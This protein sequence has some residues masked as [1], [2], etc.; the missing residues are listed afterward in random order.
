[1]L[2]GRSVFAGSVFLLSLVGARAAETSPVQ[3]LADV[4]FL[5]QYGAHGLDLSDGGPVVRGTVIVN[6]MLIPNLELGY[7]CFY[8]MRLIVSKI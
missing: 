1:M 2:Q 5:S 7:T 6:H 4:T 8:T 3:L